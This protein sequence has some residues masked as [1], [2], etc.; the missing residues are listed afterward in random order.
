MP[1][2]PPGSVSPSMPRLVAGSRRWLLLGL[3]LCGITT[4]ALAGSS[5]W[6]AT[7]VLDTQA[8]VIAVVVVV[9]ALGVGATRAVERILAEHLGQSYIHQIRGLL[10][11]T[12]LAGRSRSSAG[13]VIARITNDLTAVRTWVSL[14]IAPL[15]VAVPLLGGALVVLG[16]IHHLLAVV[17]GAVIVAMVLALVITAGPMFD[18]A[19]T[20]RRRRGRLA[21][22]TTEA[23][24]ALDSIRA[25]GGERRELNHINRAGH[26]VVKAAIARARITAIL[27]GVSAGAA[28]LAVAMVIVLAGVGAVSVGQM[29]AAAL[30]IGIVA[31]PLTDLGRIVEYRQN[32][33]AARR[34]LLPALAGQAPEQPYTR[35]SQAMERATAQDQALVVD[36]ELSD[37]TP[38]RDFTA[39]PGQRLLLTS[40]FPGR[41]DELLAL[42]TGVG[43]PTRGDIWIAGVDMARASGA[44]RRE[45]IGAARGGELLPR[46]SVD[47]AMRYRVPD[48]REGDTAPLE[49]LLGLHETIDAL[50][51]GRSTILTRGGAPLDPRGAT[52]VSVVRAAFGTPP[53]LLLDRV[54]SHLSDADLER[55]EHLVAHYPGVVVVTCGPGGA[56]P[57]WLP[58]DWQTWRL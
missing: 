1:D 6:A 39:G 30:Y 4:A 3:L 11:E 32:Y 57:S 53:V 42:V 29:T 37:G 18:R 7:H 16:V 50:P 38:V 35:V 19:K 20:L 8:Q 9:A 26:S 56:R 34:I 55:L 45:V 47:R 41:C 24:N 17:V 23:V 15:L 2:Q 44:R 40:D 51:K 13:V 49:R 25:A 10:V 43:V 31:A 14:G 28:A 27:R 5:A 52:L 21:S 48:S 22:V 36:V 58:G 54:E 46:G 12:L 33:K